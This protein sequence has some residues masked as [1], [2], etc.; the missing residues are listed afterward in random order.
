[1]KNGYAKFTIT[2][3]IIVWNVTIFDQIVPLLPLP[4]DSLPAVLDGDRGAEEAWLPGER[5]PPP[6]PDEYPELTL[7]AT[8]YV[9]VGLIVV[10]PC[11]GL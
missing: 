2:N 5:A 1:M 3:S 9:F 4:D 6:P 7:D 10:S 11:S 8:L